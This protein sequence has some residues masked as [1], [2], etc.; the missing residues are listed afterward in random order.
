[1]TEKIYL[2][3]PYLM[4][5]N[6]KVIENK[7][8]DNKFYVKLNRTIFYPHM[9]GGQPR[10]K[11]Y[12]DDIEVYDVYEQN[13][14]IIHVLRDMPNKD[15]VKLSIEW[16]TRFKHMQ[17]HT[18]QHILSASFDKLLNSKTL[19]FHMGQDIN[20]IDIDTQ[21]LTQNDIDKIESFANKIV[22][23]NFEIQNY[24]IN[25][26]ECS[27]LPLRNL[28]TVD[29]DIRI[30]EINKLDFSPCGGT[31]HRSTAEVGIIKIINWY[32]TKKYHRVEFVCGV[33]ALNDYKEKNYL[34]QKISKILQVNQNK[35]IETI[36]RIN[37]DIDNL[38]KSNT[39]LKTKLL[40]Y[41]TNWLINSSVK[42]KNIKICS[43]IVDDFDLNE[44][45]KLIS[46]VTNYNNYVVIIGIE[47]EDK[48]EILLGKSDNVSIDIKGLF[49]TILT[50]INGKGGGTPSICQGG[51]ND[52]KIVYEALEFGL[53]LIKEEI[54]RKEN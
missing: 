35:A 12:I 21:C 51:C 46:N 41:K 23:S 3:N 16:D 2:K 19:S 34:S 53:S 18:G 40:S 22:F 44:I 49:D 20:Y 52:P 10:D 39:I 1:M 43:D 9:S 28:P 33:S 13:N 42:Y 37:T 30:V 32:K 15:I 26:E 5:V 27:K 24:I 6:A 7:F 8:E 29:E 14:E 31:H 47:S 48:S 25:K 36:S 45:R 17:Q 4:E 50:K 54:D 38:K 11:G